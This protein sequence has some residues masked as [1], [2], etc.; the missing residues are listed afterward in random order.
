MGLL[1]KILDSLFGSAKEVEKAPANL[2]EAAEARKTEVSDGSI[3]AGA[4]PSSIQM[5]P[6]KDGAVTRSSD[7]TSASGDATRASGDATRP[8]KSDL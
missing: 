5:D 3:N 8:R 1:D 6:S 2:A 4:N 7:N